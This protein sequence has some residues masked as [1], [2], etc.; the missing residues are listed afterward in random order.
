MT[1]SRMG[2]V[3]IVTSQMAGRVN[4]SCELARRIESAGHTATIASPADI[5]ERVAAHGRHYQRVAGPDLATAA[6]S[7]PSGAPSRLLGFLK[8]LPQ[9]RSV[10]ARRQRKVDDLDPDGFIGSVRDLETDLLLVDMELPAHVI[11]GW[12]CGVPVVV[13]STMLALWKA[14]GLPPLGSTIIPGHEW[15]GSAFGIELAW[16]RFR[17]WKWQRTQ[18]QR[19]TRFGEDQMSVM[20]TLAERVGFPLES[21]ADPH[22]WPVPFLYKSIPLLVC[23]ASELDFPHRPWPTAHYVGPVLDP[24]RE[25]A[26]G[27]HRTLS[28]ELATLYA[29]RSSGES[30][31]LVYCSFGAWHQ[32]DDL[33]FIRTVA[34]AVAARSDW[35]LV[36]GLGGR[37]DPADLGE[38]A[39]N[40]HAYAWAPQLAVLQHA[41]VAIHH[42]GISSVNESIVAGVPMVVYPF[43][44]LDQPGNAARIVHHGLGVVGDR[45]TDGASDVLR[46]LDRVLGDPGYK[47]RVLE[48]RETF[49][50]Y[51]AAD[52]ALHF[53]LE[54]L[55]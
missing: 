23:N 42:A 39:G 28:N 34:A 27:E 11:A 55:P 15:R 44:F 48:M 41:D 52:P 53:L 37:V 47:E 10:E 45:N 54:R 20:R 16:L 18:R 33:A 32:G 51:V 17:L 38:F 30:S 19:I 36:I 2:H 12:A 6:G 14:P 7:G 22:Q 35:D 1:T 4:V 26:A 31:A 13:W 21:E 29:R 46:H 9:V 24:R 43:D 49:A 3:L 40:V 25:P 8:R 5:Q 50:R